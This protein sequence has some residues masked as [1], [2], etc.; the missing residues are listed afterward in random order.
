MKCNEEI[1]LLPDEH[2]RLLARHQ[3]PSTDI[4]PPSAQT[5]KVQRFF[6]EDDPDGLQYVVVPED[7]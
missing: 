1:R 6:R 4:V 5:V 2:K 3:R 7:K